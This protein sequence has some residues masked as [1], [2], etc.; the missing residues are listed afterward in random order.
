MTS[1]KL[2]KTREK[3][4]ISCGQHRNNR[5][6]LHLRSHL[7]ILLSKDPIS[8]KVFPLSFFNDIHMP[9]V[10]LSTVTQFDFAMPMSI[11]SPRGTW[12]TL[13]LFR[14]TI[15]NNQTN[16]KP[17]LEAGDKFCYHRTQVNFTDYAK[18]KAEGNLPQYLEWV[19]G[20]E[21]NI[22]VLGIWFK[23]L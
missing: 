14:N 17:Q 3:K 20:K 15:K 9:P 16:K 2:S 10:S 19:S 7:L 18:W 23:F 4:S 6:S 5:R 13:Y 22:S 11:I 1:S 12:N 8:S 21:R